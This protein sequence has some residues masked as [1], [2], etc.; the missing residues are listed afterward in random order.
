VAPL[1][2]LG[3]APGLREDPLE[4]NT[5]AGAARDQAVEACRQRTSK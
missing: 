2:C 5:P 4:Q 3:A 1:F